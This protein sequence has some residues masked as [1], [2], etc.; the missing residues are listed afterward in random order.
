MGADASRLDVV[1]MQ[2][3]MLMRDGEV[4]K[5]SKRSGKAITLVTLLEEIPIDAARFFF[6]TREANSHFEF[7]WIWQWK[8]LRES[9]LLCAVCTCKNLQLATEYGG[10]GR[11]YRAG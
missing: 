6:N 8:S 3:V 10:C 5:L 2:M 4:V 1:L 7:V 9:R 11:F